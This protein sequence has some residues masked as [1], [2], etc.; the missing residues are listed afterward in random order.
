MLF[1]DVLELPVTVVSAETMSCD[2]VP[3]FAL[4]TIVI[5]NLIL[6]QGLPFV[7]MSVLKSD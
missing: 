7:F 1:D 3:T 2:G 5:R 4:F 6:L